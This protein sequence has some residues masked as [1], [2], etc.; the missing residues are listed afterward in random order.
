MKNLVNHLLLLLLL[1][2]VRKVAA[3]NISN[4]YAQQMQYTFAKLEK[5]RIPYGLLIDQAVD[6]IEISK[7]PGQGL[8]NDN[9]ADIH[10]FRDIY[11]TLA[12]ARMVNNNSLV[13]P[14][15]LSARFNAARKPRTITLTGLY[16]KYA[17][18]K[19]DAYSNGL[20]HVQNGQVLDIYQGLPDPCLQ[21][22]QGKSYLIQPEPCMLTAKSN[23]LATWVNPYEVREVF[24]IAPS[25]PRYK[26]KAIYVKMPSNLWFTNQT[27]IQSFQVDF[28]DGRGYQTIS[29]GQTKQV[30][31]NS[32]GRKEWKYRLHLN[33]GQV[34]YSHSY[35]QIEEAPISTLDTFPNIAR[36]VGNCPLGTANGREYCE[37]EANERFGGELGRAYVT[38]DYASTTNKLIR[39]LIVVE[40]LDMGHIVEPEALFGST[41][42]NGFILDIRNDNSNLRGLLD[43]S[44]QKYD[45]IYVDW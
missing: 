12:T 19:S 36:T 4:D 45:I 16:M 6:F 2:C 33:N 7:F 44:T 26:G 9:I 29:L 41:T 8:N 37:I 42:I 38:I 25:V 21:K 5:S 34:K 11:Y 32:I 3:Q 1:C 15:I 39:P 22:V 14:Q 10:R 27:N 17:Q 24:T 28:N 43:G 40:G 23:R 30:Q 31:Y 18:F 20:V 13:S 35:I